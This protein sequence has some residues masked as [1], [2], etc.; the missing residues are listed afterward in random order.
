MICEG[1]LR[2]EKMSLALT[3]V[4]L[5][6]IAGITFNSLSYAVWNWKNH[7]RTGSVAVFLVSLAAIA[8]PVYMI[9]FLV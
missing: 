7:N 8:L 6:L 2:G 1:E 9:F 4:V 5:I 3:I